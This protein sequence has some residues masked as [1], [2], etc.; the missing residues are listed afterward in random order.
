M[1]RVDADDLTERFHELGVNVNRIYDGP[2][3]YIL[4]AVN[5]QKLASKREAEAL[6]AKV[7]AVKS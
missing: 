2:A 3:G 7:K 6:L 5:G 1:R 4:L